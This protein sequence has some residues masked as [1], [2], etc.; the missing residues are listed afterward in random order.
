MQ[1]INWNIS[2]I[3]IFDRNKKFTSNFLIVFFINLNFILWMNNIYHSQI[4][5]LFERFN[6]TM[7]IA[8][9]Y[10][11]AKNSNINWIAILSTLQTQLNNA[12]NII[13]NRLFNEIVYELKIR[14]VLTV[15][16]RKSIKVDNVDFERFRHQR[17][18]VDVTSYVMIKAKIIYDSRHI[19]LLFKLN[20][21][22][23]F[24]ISQKIFII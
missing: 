15:L 11:I 22:T 16:N 20:D 8:L 19:F 12:F 9:R 24:T 14:I 3:I 1:L 7:K 13:T 18:I 5:D 10:L 23:F 4:N 17:K 6:Q 2:K 21:K